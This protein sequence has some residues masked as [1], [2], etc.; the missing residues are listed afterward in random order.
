M[1]VG[2]GSAAWWGAFCWSC[3]TPD[4]GSPICRSC[5]TSTLAPSM[6][7]SA[8]IGRVFKVRAGL[9]KRRAIA[10]GESTSAAQLLLD[11][12]GI[13]DVAKS[14]LGTPEPSGYGA[15]NTLSRGW[16]LILAAMAVEGGRES[17][18][19]DPSVLREAGM[20]LCST[21][22]ETRLLA[23][24]ALTAGM[25]DL[26]VQLPLSENER[27]WLLASHH[28]A[29]GNTAAAL[30]HLVRL[31]R[32][33]YP[34]KE[35]IVVRC[36]PEIA[37]GAADR[38]LIGSHLEPFR[39]RSPLSDLLWRLLRGE[40]GD[41]AG[42]R[43][44][45]AALLDVLGLA[46]D[47]APRRRAQ[48]FLSALD[49]EMR[50][51]EDISEV[52]SQ[53]SLLMAL[54][55]AK[56]RSPAPS[57]VDVGAVLRESPSVRDDIFDAG[58]IDPEQIRNVPRQE[59]V[60]LLGRLAPWEL[61]DEEVAASGFH[62]EIAR[63]AFLAGDRRR[64]ESLPQGSVRERFLLLDDLRSG[65]TDAFE[66][67]SK[68]LLANE[69][70]VA[71][72][73]VAWL[74]AGGRG[75]VPPSLL[76]DPS[77]WETIRSVTEAPILPSDDPGAEA[78]R[79]WLE[80][81]NAK[82]ALL[83][84]NW[85]GALEAAKE[86][87]RLASDEVVRDEAL[88]MIACA[89]WQ[90]GN[91]EA[92]IQALAQALEGNYTEGLQVNIGVVAAGLEPQIAAEHLGQLAL[93]A[94]TLKLRV[95]AAMRALAL[96]T[97]TREG[98]EADEVTDE[99]PAKLRRALRALATEPVELDQFRRIVKLL[100]NWDAEWLR[101]SANLASS[102]HRETLEAELYVALAQ[103]VPE[104]VKVLAHALRSS[105]AV[106]VTEE[107]DQMIDSALAALVTDSPSLGAAL[108]GVEI[109]TS[110]VP[111]EA[112]RR[113]PLTAFAVA[114]VAANIDPQEGEPKQKFLDMLIAAK[115]ELEAVP[116]G[117][118]ERVG[119]ALDY[120]FVRLGAAYGAARTI[121]LNQVVD[122]YNQILFRIS[123]VPRWHIDRSAVRRATDPLL[124]FCDGT[125]WLMSQLTPHVT[126]A[127]VREGLEELRAEAQRV[128]S[129]IRSLPR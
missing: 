62:E 106:W 99:M 124:Q 85:V 77:T 58:L 42:L 79:V 108:F 54:A 75:P 47:S 63:R 15:G 36:W 122:A 11:G 14:H 72:D 28:A 81:H 83:D 48:A 12:G 7:R 90:L 74:R 118:R 129:A 40:P 92:A 115:K 38:D 87:L 53:A 68:F 5:G 37:E 121:Q 9:R 114:A 78:F 27:N 110:G 120:A 45:V 35:R 93:E 30:E 13:Q 117:E 34:D 73:L 61:S 98:W 119:K 23:L 25:T 70:R 57:F 8:V 107:R 127:E 113:V 91:V 95:A 41:V 101:D 56:G 22:E 125:I 80:L 66:S 24:D 43:R 89:H 44:G 96:W 32:D 65:R 1:T 82:A 29:R 21:L 123:G 76:A 69:R 94:P 26:I 67:A 6:S 55:H 17:A 49:P 18:L 100:A 103:G 19:W 2:A 59:A 39:D 52:G 126:Q 60:G 3:G 50:F 109:L 105:D 46:I 51:G 31:P 111:L 64:L 84:W 71:S 97:L 116:D 10:L 112:G 128:G 16:P 4:P 104:F 20:A 86:C 33:G 88:N 102:P